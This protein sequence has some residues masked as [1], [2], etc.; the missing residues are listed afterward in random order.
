MNLPKKHICPESNLFCFDCKKQICRQCMQ[1]TRTAMKCSNCSPQK[2][3]GAVAASRTQQMIGLEL[4][5]IIYSMMLIKLL[6]ALSA[7]VG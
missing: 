6:S 1:V 3:R 2:P 5:T 7:C 4:A